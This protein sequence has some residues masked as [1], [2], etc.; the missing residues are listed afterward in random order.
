MHLKKKS[1]KLYFKGMGNFGGGNMPQSNPPS[2][3]GGGLPPQQRGQVGMGG[4]G[5]G[6]HP[7]FGVSGLQTGSMQQQAHNQFML[8]RQGKAPYIISKLIFGIILYLCRKYL[9]K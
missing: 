3:F 5:G 6:N 8:H 9:A 4:M 1:A 2:L 7:S